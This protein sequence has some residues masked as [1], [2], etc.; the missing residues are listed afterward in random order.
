MSATISEGLT[1]EFSR[2]LRMLREAITLFPADRWRRSQI[3]P[4]IPGRQALHII[5]AIDLYL[6]PQ[7]TPGIAGGAERFGGEL[8]WEGSR[9]EQLPSQEELLEYLDE[10]E[11][12]LKTW[13][14]TISDADL[15]AADGEF[16]WSGPNRLTRMLYLLG[17][18]Q[19]HQGLLH[20]ELRRLDIPRPSW[21]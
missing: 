11:A 17:H 15:L 14:G 13:L 7:Y 1:Q 20:N 19:H 5:G 10:V 3:D 2:S 9:A 21:D 4:L 16:E 6:R 8:D 18:N 12:K